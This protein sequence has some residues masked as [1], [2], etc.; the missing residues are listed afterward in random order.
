M[1]LLTVTVLGIGVA[2]AG[3]AALR[4]RPRRLAGHRQAQLRALQSWQHLAAAEGLEL[5]R[6]ARITGSTVEGTLRR[7]RFSA[8]VR[9]GGGGGAEG[10]HTTRIVLAP[11]FP[12]A[13]DTAVWLRGTA[14]LRTPPRS[15]LVH[16]DVLVAGPDAPL[17]QRSVAAFG[18]LAQE[19]PAATI[20]EGA[21]VAEFPGVRD[22]LAALCARLEAVVDAL[23]QDLRQ[24]WLRAAARLGLALRTRPHGANLEGRRAGGRWWLSI[25]RVQEGTMVDARLT[26]P[27]GALIRRRT[28]RDPPGRVGNPIADRFLHAEGA[29][30]RRC[31]QSDEGLAAAMAVLH[32]YP[33]SRV[34]EDGVHLVAEGDAV[35][36]GSL[37]LLVRAAE[38]L[39]GALCLLGGGEE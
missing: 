15:R 31:L 18:R 28:S 24:P 13:E 7:R 29:R 21:L 16:G 23:E 8:V 14:W 27:E 1:E 36:D 4:L 34:D 6:R 30:A 39:A 26:L 11:A 19:V 38:D 12:F 20:C 3:V 32:A 33:D 17:L 22:D 37:P 25:A 35:R 2:L 10:E 5:R 9:G